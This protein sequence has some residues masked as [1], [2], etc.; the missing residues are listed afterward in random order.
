MRNQTHDV[1]DTSRRPGLD[2]ALAD[3]RQHLLC[4][5][6]HRRTGVMAEFPG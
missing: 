6:C 2:G 4:M 3:R 5:V 1:R